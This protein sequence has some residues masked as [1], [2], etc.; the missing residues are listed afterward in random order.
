MES[1]VPRVAFDMF[2][3]I[4]IGEGLQT[5]CPGRAEQQHLEFMRHSMAAFTHA[6]QLGREP[7]QRMAAAKALGSK[8]QQFVDAMDAAYVGHTS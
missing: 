7:W 3:A 6:G 4:A 1:F 8:W 5:A 2:V